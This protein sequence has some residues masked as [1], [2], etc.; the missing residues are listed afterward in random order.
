MGE[1]RARFAPSPTGRFHSGS[2]RT[3]LFT[4]SLDIGGKLV[5]RIEDTDRARSSEE[6]EQ[7]LLDSLNWLGLYF[8]EG[9]YRQSERGEIYKGSS[10]PL[11]ERTDVRGGRRRGRRAFP[12]SCRIAQV[13]SRRVAR[14]GPLQQGQ[15]L[16]DHQVRRHAF[17]QLR[18]R[19]G[20]PRDG[21]NSNVIRGEEHLS[22]TAPPGAPIPRAGC[23]RTGVHPPRPDP[24]PRRQAASASG[25]ARRASPSTAAMHTCRRPS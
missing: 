12:S 8:D 14:R 4:S 21:D 17:L 25:T 11:G 13:P 19:R 24:R 3:A 18:R 15:G 23:R 10:V 1:V 9:P 2:A 22:N 5:L 20:R 16:R 6:F 7:D